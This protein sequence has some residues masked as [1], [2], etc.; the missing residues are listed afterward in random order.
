MARHMRALDALTAA[1]AGL[2]LAFALWG[3]LI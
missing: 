1:L 2:I 3:L